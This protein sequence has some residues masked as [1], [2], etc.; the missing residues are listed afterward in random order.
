MN[1]RNF[2]RKDIVDRKV[3]RVNEVNTNRINKRKYYGVGVEKKEYKEAIDYHVNHT[4]AIQS[5]EDQIVDVGSA[6]EDLAEDIVGRGDF[7]RENADAVVEDVEEPL[8]NSFEKGTRR[9]FDEQGDTLPPADPEDSLEDILQEQKNYI[10]KLT[11]EMR[12][13][14][15]EIIRSGL[16]AG[17]AKSTII[18]N[19]RNELKSLQ[20]NRGE[21]IAETE[22]VA[23]AG[24]GAVATFKENGVS[25]L[26]WIAEIDTKTC[27]EG[28][29]TTTYNGTT[30]TSCPELHQEEFDISGNH[31]VPVRDS[32]VNCRC[33]LVAVT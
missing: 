27:E 20:E 13:K 3:D 11:S 17:L 4:A 26:R 12:Q 29:F 8:T 33:V 15:I 28:A 25:K 7:L 30:Y 10:N 24:L 5:L 16:A 1:N 18:S 6:S 22:T 19:L 14:A 32:H 21:T 23:A 31:P 9:A 2:Q